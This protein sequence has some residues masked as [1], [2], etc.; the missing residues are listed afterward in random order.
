MANQTNKQ[1]FIGMLSDYLER[2]GVTVVQ[3]KGDADLLIVQTSIESAKTVNTVLVGDD[4]D[5]LVLLCFHADIS[6]TSKDIFFIP[7]A[8]QKAGSRRVWN[9]KKTKRALGKEI[10]N[11]I[12][13][14]HAIL[15]CNTTSRAHGIGKKTSLKKAKSSS[16]FAKLAA[17]FNKD[18]A[19]LDEV[20]Q[21]GE[22][23][24][25]C[26]YNGRI[27]ESLNTLRYKRFK[28]KVA[29]VPGLWRPKSCLRHLQLQ[30]TIACVCIFKFKNGKGGEASLTHR[31]GAG[32]L[33]RSN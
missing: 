12:L 7:K 4:T 1:R 33:V 31:I 14:L 11:Q 21:A 20:I 26:L 8:K 10:C 2:S 30:S 22:K 17:I 25:A 29:R 18:N 9:I 15:G 6:Q 13:F 19:T 32:G 24:L 23:A 27:D 16:E 3:A 28:D 5:L